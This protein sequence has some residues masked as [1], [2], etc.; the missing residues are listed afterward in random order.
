MSFSNKHWRAAALAAA[1]LPA[2]L[3]ADELSLTGDERLSGTVRAIHADGA[4]LLETPLSPE[5]LLF[6]P[7]AVNRVVFS[8]DGEA[9]ADG[10]CLLTL[11]NGDA[12]P[13]R[14]EEI[15]DERVVISSGLAGRL[16]IP[17]AAVAALRPGL[18]HPRAVF[19]GPGPLEG[20]TRVGRN[21]E[22]CTVDDGSLRLRGAYVGA[23]RK[24]DLPE[25]FSL[26]FR[27]SWNNEPNL[28]V[29]FAADG[30]QD[31][32]PQD[33]YY[34]TFNSAGIEIKRETAAPGQR[35]HSMTSLGR[36]P[37]QFPGRQV[38]VEI[39]V[40]RPAKR[41][42]LFLNGEDEGLTADPL[43]DAPAGGWLAFF[44]SAADNSHCDISDIQVAEWNQSLRRDTG[45]ERGDKS[46]D[47]LVGVDGER[48]AGTL[49]AAA[50][51]A[52]GALL[53]TFRDESSQDSVKV[54]VDAVSA[55]YL[56]EQGKDQDGP[57]PPFGLRLRGGG[58][59]RVTEC[60]FTPDA[61]EATHPVLGN[62]R[63]KRAAVAAF[64]RKQTE[65]EEKKQ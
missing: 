50:R 4:V 25:Q 60:A 56:A 28:K 14:L 22:N 47:A 43:A 49:L 53:F 46:K 16:E 54:P 3:A 55:I 6:K 63:L 62:I 1:A 52:G 5:P 45:G 59:L 57:V 36:R 34:L 32:D 9:A 20:W 8:E 35:F 26:R 27:L 30:G 11:A 51:D 38:L 41:L 48:F 64:E 15:D 23:G 65:P 13:G 10:D 37:D 31:T 19:T 40:D 24:L 29:S 17:R 58:T 33:R 2:L 7:G 12:L 39:V 44:G 21:A 18:N 61:V 42:Q